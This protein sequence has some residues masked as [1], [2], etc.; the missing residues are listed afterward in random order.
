MNAR[1]AAAP[2]VITLLISNCILCGKVKAS[3]IFQGVGLYPYRAVPEAVSD[4]LSTAAS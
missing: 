3:Q 2:K 4:R 1:V